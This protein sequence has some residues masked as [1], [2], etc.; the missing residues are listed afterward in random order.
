MQENEHLSVR[1]DK[2]TVVSLI[3]RVLP[4]YLQILEDCSNPITWRNLAQRFSENIKRLKIENYVHLYE[5]EKRIPAALICAVMS[6]EEQAEFIAEINAASPEEQQEILREYGRPGGK[7]D[8]LSDEMFPEDAETQ[9]QQLEAFERLE[10]EERTEAVKRGQYLM[11]F[12]MAWLHD[13]LAVMV[14]GQRMTDLVPKALAGDKSA[15]ALAVQVDKNLIHEHP[16]FKE[17]HQKALTEGDT[18]FLEK[19]GYRLAAPVTR[20]PIRYAGVFVLFA[21]LETM[22]WLDALRHREILDICDA[23]NLDRWQNR[24]EDEN[25]I[26]KCLQ[27]YRRYQKTGGVSMH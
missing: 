5:D 9:Q 25:A 20:G 6:K 18:D 2:E 4:D 11:G 1:P 7:W 26:T 21:M 16:G 22:K 23:A 17:I 8:Q 27:K 10:G 3:T 24:I 14:F 13:T 19:V 15:Y 12:F